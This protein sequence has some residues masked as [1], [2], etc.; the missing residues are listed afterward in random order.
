MHGRKL[1][2][3]G[4][5]AALAILAIV[6]GCKEAS[7]GPSS[8]KPVDFA[9]NLKL[10]S[11]NQQIGAVGAALPEVL[12]VKVVD[13]GGLPVAGAT[14]LWQVRQG[15]GTI[16]PPA[17]TSSSTGL[18]S[19]TWTLGKS[20]PGANTDK[21]VAILQGNYVLDSV[22]FTASTKEGPA[23]IFTLVSGNQQTARVASVLSSPLTVNV[24]DQFGNP[25]KGVRVTWAAGLF[26]GSVRAV[27]D[28]TDNTGTASANWTL[29]TSAIAQSA[30]ATVTGL[31]PVTFNATATADTSR[32]LTLVSGGAQSGSAGSQLA[33]NIVVRVAD[34]YGNV[35]V[36]DTVIFTD[37]TAGGG[38]IGTQR[39]GTDASGQ[40]TTT[41]TLGQRVGTQF[42][43]ARI[44]TRQERVSVTS[45]ATVQFTQ[46]Y[47]GNYFACGVSTG[48]RAYCWGFGEDGQRGVAATKSSNAPGAAVTSLD[49]LAG[50]FPTWRQIAAGSSYIC[51]ISIARQLY[52][53]GR[54]ATAVQATM[55]TLK[56][57]SSVLSFASVSNSEVHSCLLSTDGQLGCSGSNARGQLGD[58]TR[59]DQ[60]SDY[61]VVV[62]AAP[63]ARMPW[64][65]V[66]TGGSHTCAFP[67]FNPADSA[68]TLRPWCWGANGSGQLGNATVSIDSTIPRGIDMTAR[69]MVWDTTSLVAG[70]A[71]SCALT[72]AGAAYCWGSNSDGQLGGGTALVRD[73]VVQAVAGG[74]T[75]AKL[76]AG[77]Y[78]TCGITTTS[79]AYCWGRNASGQLGDGTRTNANSPVLVAGG[80]TWRSL[81]L[82]ELHSCGVASPTGIS[83]GTQA[84]AGV[85]YCWGDNEYGQ[86]GI[87][88]TGSNGTP[89]LTPQRVSGQP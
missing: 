58:G 82:G 71:H 3:T 83:S 56:S 54:L 12:T 45:T 72:R 22:V 28:T 85:I 8:V 33:S 69:T 73:S 6:A 46:V 89:S 10:L 79:S 27:A 42:M 77:E 41:W 49:T 81:A 47:S 68:N 17:S 24:K 16:N 20:T 7:T 86:L 66:A 57:F 2:T 32:R 64:S 51:G 4:T 35:I 1:V 88:V 53:W 19:V 11:G 34:Q 15:G 87:G 38:I 39:A 78:H 65:S 37:S 13:A 48:D 80:L 14:V 18:A 67:R 25:V 21:V 84:G 5:V 40:A 60:T 70:V 31:G 63:N 43:R 76:Y 36:G 23:G 50:P 59:G 55:P 9:A 30:T 61:V 74:F 29:G 26:S 52:C 44:A 62:T 75:F